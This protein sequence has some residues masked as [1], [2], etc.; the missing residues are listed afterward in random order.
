ML[1]PAQPYF[2]PLKEPVVLIEGEFLSVDKAEEWF[3]SKYGK[4]AKA[5]TMNMTSFHD[6]RDVYIITEVDYD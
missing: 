6:D 3:V 5:W 4:D 2:H 1:V